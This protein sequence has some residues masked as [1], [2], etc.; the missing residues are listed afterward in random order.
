[1]PLNINWFD[2]H[3]EVTLNGHVSFK[4]LKAIGA[5]HYGDGRFDGIKYVVVDFRCAN[6]TEITPDKPKILASIDST[7]VVYNSNLKIAFIIE[8]EYQ[9][10]LCEKYVAD[11]VGFQSS[12][13]HGIFSNMTSAK[14]WCE[15]GDVT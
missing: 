3:T 13:S 1:M 2:D 12:W 14:A 4:E 15:V 11:S 9:R 8:N 7:A 5:V 10:Q 6:L